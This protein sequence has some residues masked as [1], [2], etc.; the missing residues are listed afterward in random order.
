M[1]SCTITWCERKKLNWIENWI[2]MWRWHSLDVRKIT[3]VKTLRGDDQGSSPYMVTIIVLTLRRP[4]PFFVYKYLPAD[5][6][7]FVFVYTNIGN[8]SNSKAWYVGIFSWLNNSLRPKISYLN[9]EG[10]SVIWWL[11][12]LPFSLLIELPE[13]RKWRKLNFALKSKL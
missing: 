4:L 6:G 2:V 10:R 12:A 11:I 8:C 7:L 3:K 13:L 5:H 9:V 1:T